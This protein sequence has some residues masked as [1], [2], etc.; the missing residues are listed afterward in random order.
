MIYL[1]T[2][3]VNLA[4]TPSLPQAIAFDDPL[5]DFRSKHA[6]GVPQI[7]QNELF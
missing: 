4:H 1:F 5:G 3:K 6:Q 7:L 2:L